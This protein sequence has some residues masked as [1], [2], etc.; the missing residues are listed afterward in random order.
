LHQTNGWTIYH[1]EHDKRTFYKQEPGCLYGSVIT[2]CVVEA[3]MDHVVACYDNIEVCEEMMPDFHDLK[4]CTKITDVKG[5][6][7]GK[8]YF[9]W[10]MATREMYMHVTGVFDPKNKAVMSV[11]QSIPTG[12]KYYEYEVPEPEYGLVR[13]N[14]K[15]GYNYF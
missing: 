13:L 8:Q 15:M 1:N 14:I 3:P 2:D 9:P 12:Q 5:V 6:L 4:W 10:P 11:S 7:K